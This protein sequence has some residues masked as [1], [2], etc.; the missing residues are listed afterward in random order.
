[1]I[2]TIISS[3]LAAVTI[4]YAYFN[5]YTKCIYLITISQSHQLK[6][7]HSSVLIAQ[8]ILPTS[9]LQITLN[10]PTISNQ[11][12]LLKQVLQIKTLILLLL[13]SSVWR[14]SQHKNK[15]RNSENQ[16]QDTVVLTEE[17]KLI[18]CS[19]W[20]MLKLDV[21]LEKVRIKLMEKE[22]RPLEKQANGCQS[23]K[24]LHNENCQGI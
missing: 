11:S 13:N 18:M 2:K 12:M 9:K 22:R 19:V 16:F 17:Y 5:S 24:E 23:I 1:M 8:L 10:K 15:L 6:F 4:I 20:P 21:W 14:M 7:M 3:S